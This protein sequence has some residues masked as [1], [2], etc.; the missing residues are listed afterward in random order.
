MAPPPL[1]FEFNDR[2]LSSIEVRSGIQQIIFRLKELEDLNVM[3][4][5]RHQSSEIVALRKSVEDTLAGIFGK[6]TPR[7]RRFRAAAALEPLPSLAT[8]STWTATKA[9]KAVGLRREI[10]EL[11]RDIEVRRRRSIEILNQVI[12]YLSDEIPR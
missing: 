6:G 9:S 8:T 2:T 5:N 10:Q 1:S 7:F 12:Q 3:S 11:R 4:V